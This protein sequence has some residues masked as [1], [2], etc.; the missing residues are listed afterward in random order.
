M[1]GDGV[2]EGW[3]ALQWPQRRKRPT[4]EPMCG[5]IS[6]KVC[7]ASPCTHPSTSK[8]TW[9]SYS[10]GLFS[11]DTLDRDAGN[12]GISN[13]ALSVDLQLSELVPSLVSFVALAVLRC[14]EGALG[15]ACLSHGGSPG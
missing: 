4:R 14:M 6:L 7:I 1:G 9:T 3:G 2:E 15:G 11:A 8:Y 12:I 13:D 5:Y 10:Q